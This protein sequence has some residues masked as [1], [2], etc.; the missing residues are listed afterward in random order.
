MSKS[1]KDSRDEPIFSLGVV[2]LAAGLSARMGQ[3][4][5][6]LPWGN[7][8]VLGH[9]I[10]QWRR[11]GADQIAIV[12]AAGASAIA[13]ELD[14][15]SFSTDNRIEN[16]GPER[17]MFSSIQC[18]ADWRGWVPA[19]THWAI[20]L[21]DQPHLRHET[22]ERV[23]DLAVSHPQKIVQPAHGGRPRH[24]VLVPKPPFTQLAGATVSNLK[25]FLRNYEVKV[26][27]LEDPGLDLDI[28]RLEDY[29]KALALAGFT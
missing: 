4:K 3:P 26:C 21:G 18:A 20:V 16:P 29:K 27:E 6:L 23:L 9:L 15:L 7:T 10:G 13:T 25:E 2:L 14:R 1:M 19:L 17:G 5:L 22:L 12:L 11:L 24:P 28:D 8:S